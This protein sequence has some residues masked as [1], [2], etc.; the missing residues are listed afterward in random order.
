MRKKDTCPRCAAPITYR[1]GKYGEFVS[2][3]RY[4]ACDW[5]ASFEEWDGCGEYPDN[6]LEFEFMKNN[7]P[8]NEILNG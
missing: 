2:C 7:D 6:W 8:T 3:S 4:P 5:S 1:H